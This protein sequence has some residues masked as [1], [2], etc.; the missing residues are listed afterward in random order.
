MT[1]ASSARRPGARALSRIVRACSVAAAA[2]LLAPL[3]A[4]QQFPTKTVRLIVPNAPGGAID[5][6]ARLFSQHLQPLWGGQPVIVDYKPGAGTALGTEIVAKSAPDGHTL[7]FVVTSHVINPSMRQLP[8]DTVKDL[9]GVTMYGVTHILISATPGLQVS[10]IGDVIALAR[11]Q[12]GKL[13]YAS[14]GSGSSMHMAGELLKQS[15]GIDVLHVPFKGSG[16]AFPEVF[17]GRIEL[18]IDPLFSSM[19]HVKAGRMKAIAITSPTRTPA[20]PQIPTVA[21]TIPGFSVQSVFGIVVPA[22]TPRDLVRRLHADILKVLQVPEFKAKMAEFG[23]EPVGNTPEQ[24]DAF[25]RAEIEKWAKVVK[26]A[27]IKA[28]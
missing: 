17:S 10:T 20:A 27:G 5:I 3:A 8:F 1:D 15:A 28:D 9:A 21:E 7:G 13:S 2:A 6:M 26:A 4:A 23:M 11:K 19:P 22:A 24:F 18:I 12:P 16:P 25:I 14:P